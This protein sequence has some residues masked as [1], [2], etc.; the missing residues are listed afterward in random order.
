MVFHG[1]A[2]AAK[3]MSKTAR[4]CRA[5]VFRDPKQRPAILPWPSGLPVADGR[6]RLVS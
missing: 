5:R 1:F 2:E 6:F 4:G 3:A